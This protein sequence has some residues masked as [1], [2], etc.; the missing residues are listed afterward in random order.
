VEALL[1]N[2]KEPT[3]SVLS[4]IIG[5]VVLIFGASG[6]F[7]ELQKALNTIWEVEPR[8]G[9][10]IWG[11]VRDRFFSFSL[12]LGVAFLLLVSLTFSAVLSALGKFLESSLPGGETLWQI[13]N[14]VVSFGIIT[15]LF[16]LLL[17]V[18]PD[19]KAPW[20]G[21]WPGAAVTA[22][23]YTVGKFGLGLYLGRAS[24]SSPYG[25]AG[26]IVV[27]VIWVYYAAQIFF[28]GAE[29]TREYIRAKGMKV[30]PAR[31]AVP[32]KDADGQAPA[33]GAE[34]HA[35]GPALE[36]SVPARSSR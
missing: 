34:P 21:I 31:D 20:R 12:V 16:A 1:K 24:V 4:S 14:F 25:A 9:R 27:L 36:A 35:R 17:R 19:V 5:V 6:V 28:L 26:S 13:I 3:G 2:A 22:L 11:F 23:L 7:G 10:G 29:F 8:P 32:A 33:G 15:A 30:R 18:V